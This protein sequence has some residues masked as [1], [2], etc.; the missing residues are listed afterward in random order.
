MLHADIPLRKKKAAATRL[1]LLDALHDELS[2]QDLAQIRVKDLCAR[3]SISEPTFFK[4]FPGKADLLTYALQLWCI[5]TRHKAEQAA[6]R[7]GIEYLMVIFDEMAGSWSRH[8]RLW[9]EVFA[10]Q[11]SAAPRLR[12]APPAYAELRLRFPQLTAA[13]EHVPHAPD[14]LV[15]LGLQRALEVRELPGSTNLEAARQAIVGLFFGVP[16]AARPARVRQV[17]RRSLHLLWLGLNAVACEG[18]LA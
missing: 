5:E 12:Q 8:P 7:S 16:A 3:V 1:A 15:Q 9:A 17:Y 2:R 6:P 4:Y 14:E 13:E 11:L 18:G 10:H